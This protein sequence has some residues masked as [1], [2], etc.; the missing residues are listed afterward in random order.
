MLLYYTIQK[1]TYSSKN[2]KFYKSIIV[3]HRMLPSYIIFFFLQ[4]YLTNFF[5][6]H[7]KIFFMRILY[8]VGRWYVLVTMCRMR[9][10]YRILIWCF[11]SALQRALFSNN[12]RETQLSNRIPSKWN[13]CVQL[14]AVQASAH[15]T[16]MYQDSKLIASLV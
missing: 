12:M 3:Y 13:K 1:N 14:R 7:L 15:S 10:F 5:F 2:K 11:C 9:Y 16:Y 6:Q 8:V 4:K